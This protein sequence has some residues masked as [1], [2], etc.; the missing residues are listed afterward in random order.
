M[1]SSS[2]L[3]SAQ[4]ARP[5][6]LQFYRDDADYR[7][8]FA[9]FNLASKI[10]MEKAIE[11]RGNS[12]ERGDPVFNY[13][14]CSKNFISL[15]QEA[16]MSMQQ[17]VRMKG[18]AVVHP[19]TALVWPGLSL[20][21][22]LQDSIP[23]WSVHARNVTQVFGKWVF[24]PLMQCRASIDEAVCADLSLSEVEASLEAVI[25]WLG[26]DYNPW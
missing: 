12:C 25:P 1:L 24:D 5:V 6:P 7:R 26:G 11:E 15:W 14:A 22:F 4:W 16:G 8:R 21:H 9:G 17:H 10:A 23:A 3:L 19:G 13:Q 20:Q 18:P 2:P